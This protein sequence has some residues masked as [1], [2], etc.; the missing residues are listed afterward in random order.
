MSHTATNVNLETFPSVFRLSQEITAATVPADSK[1]RQT[2]FIVS[3]QPPT[4]F[5]CGRAVIIHYSLPANAIYTRQIYSATAIKGGRVIARKAI[6]TLE[7]AGLRRS[8]R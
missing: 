7:A 3:H 2:G 8:G 6:M 4:R 5:T 1:A